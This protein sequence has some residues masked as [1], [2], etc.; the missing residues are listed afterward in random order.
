MLREGKD[1]NT[2]NKCYHCEE[3]DLA[4]LDKY[5]AKECEVWCKIHKSCNLE[6][7]KHSL[8]LKRRK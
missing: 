1:A 8:K 4:Y 5:K 6:I 3:C 7:V 2:G